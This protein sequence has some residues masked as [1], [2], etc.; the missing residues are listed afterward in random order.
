MR[1]PRHFV[2]RNDRRVRLPRHFIPRND[3]KVRLIRMLA[4]TLLSSESLIKMLPKKGPVPFF[5]F[6]RDDVCVFGQKGRAIENLLES[7]PVFFDTFEYI[8]NSFLH[9]SHM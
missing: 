3:M 1:L 9:Y 8:G 2:P 5:L 7:H 6:L 4:M